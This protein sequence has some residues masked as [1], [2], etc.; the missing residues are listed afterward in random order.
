MESNSNQHPDDN[1]NSQTRL[2]EKCFSLSIALQALSQSVSTGND[3]LP[4]NLQTKLDLIGNQL[5]DL[6]L[7]FDIWMSDIDINLG[8]LH[9]NE[10]FKKSSPHQVIDTA[11][12]RM[13][14]QLTLV[15]SGITLVKIT[16]LRKYPQEHTIW[17]WKRFIFKMKS[18]RPSSK[19]WGDAFLDIQTAVNTVESV[20][21]ILAEIV[22]P[23]R[24]WITMNSGED[25]L[26]ELK[27][28]TVSTSGKMQIQESQSEVEEARSSEIPPNSNTIDRCTQC[29]KLFELQDKLAHSENC[30]KAIASRIDA[31]DKEKLNLLITESPSTNPIESTADQGK[32]RCSKAKDALLALAVSSRPELS[33]DQ[34]FFPRDRILQLLTRNN[35][36]EILECT[37]QACLEDRKHQVLN[38]TF[39]VYAD[40]IFG[41]MFQERRPTDTAVSLFALLLYIG[42][43]LFIIGFLS[44]HSDANDDTF[45]TRIIEYAS[46]D[47]LIR[48]W[49]KYHSNDRDGSN[50]LVSEF[51]RCMYQFAVPHLVHSGFSVYQDAAIL[52]FIDEIDLPNQSPQSKSFR[53]RIW[54]EYNKLPVSYHFKSSITHLKR[55]TI[56]IS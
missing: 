34:R 50:A 51:H 48:Y 23:L 22:F 6:R 30:S 39:E 28:Q 38:K 54:H 12:K 13:E 25:P 37:C 27:D 45:E 19:F 20:L 31:S 15:E 43:P 40:R 8:T 7:R 16:W 2:T 14:T 55:L 44:D 3:E 11:F 29:L 18:N 47:F 5:K 10:S 53:F 36:V 49:P 46:E 42:R 35:I 4:V 52:P 41:N 24:L 32:A 21:Q 9:E 17:S 26:R 1:S 56:S 33:T